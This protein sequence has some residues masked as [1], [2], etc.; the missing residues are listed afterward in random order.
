MMSKDSFQRVFHSM[1]DMVVIMDARGFIVDVNRSCTEKLGWSPEELMGQSIQ[2]LF[3]YRE[4][5]FEEGHQKELLCRG[6]VNNTEKEWISKSGE[7]VPV[8]FS[9]SCVV[10]EEGTVEGFVCLASD[11]R[12]RREMESQLLEAYYEKRVAEM[13]AM[14]KSRFISNM[15]HEL[16]TPLNA[17]LGYSEILLED[18]LDKGE[19]FLARDLKKI[20]DAG[21]RLLE[22]VNDILELSNLDA[23]KQE[24]VEEVIDID[25][26]TN[27]LG[28]VIEG[29][30]A[31]RGNQFEV[32]RTCSMRET[33]IDSN[34]LYLCLMY[35]LDNACKFTKEG[36]IS[37]RVGEEKQEGH[38]WIVWEVEDT[39]IGM[40]KDQLAGAFQE[41]MQADLS[42]TRAYEGT[43]LGLAITKKYIELM[44]GTIQV[45]SEEGKGT[46]F[47]L[48]LPYSPTHSQP[49]MMY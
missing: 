34:K 17:V 4:P 24:L 5:L 19:E 6:Y 12:G 3:R 35:L 27:E 23:G 8:F 40:T 39:G 31:K 41:F 21:N 46:L 30:A 7:H 43:G 42:A 14:A 9:C 49:F 1:V 18:A 28:E 48:K 13:A 37:L 20:Y 15:S 33:K 11:L 29:M 2:R 32:I 47:T 22:M 44:K 10:K 36:M 38:H 25:T 16:R 26:F 45:S